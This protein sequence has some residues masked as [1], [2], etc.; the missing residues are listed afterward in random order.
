Y[1]GIALYMWSEVVM[2]QSLMPGDVVDV[3]G[4]YTEF[5]GLSQ[6]V[7]KN[8]GDLTVTGSAA[9]PEPAI[10]TAG[11]VARDNAGA[12]PWEGGRGRDVDAEIAEPNDGFGQ[13]L[14]SGGALVGNAFVDPLP[15]VQ[16]GGTF[17]SVT[18][19]LHFS[20]EEFKIQPTSAAD[21]A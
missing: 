16:V 17:S 3:T 13:Y 18:G 19:P 8:P 2:S 10:V 12:E 6:L 1:S 9:V 7:V 20:Y 4:E 14:L 21:L 15:Q 5:F 11:E